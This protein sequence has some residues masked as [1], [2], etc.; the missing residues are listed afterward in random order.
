MQLALQ[1]WDFCLHK[2]RGLIVVQRVLVY[3]TASFLP[4]IKILH[5]DGHLSKL[6][7]QQWCIITN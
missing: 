4:I 7:N 6:K 5:K 2:Y 3:P 1:I